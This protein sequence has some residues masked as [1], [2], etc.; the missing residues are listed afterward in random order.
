MTLSKGSPVLKTVDATSA[1]LVHDGNLDTCVFCTAP[2]V[3][4]SACLEEL[5]AEDALTHLSETVSCPMVF[6]ATSQAVGEAHK[7]DTQTCTGGELFIAVCPPENAEMQ[8]GGEW[9]RGTS[10]W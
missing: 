9:L 3:A 6:C 2:L 4:R 1:G 7:S 5:N 10:R 8:R